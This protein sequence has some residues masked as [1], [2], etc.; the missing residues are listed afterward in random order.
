MV[1]ISKM[2]PHCESCRHWRAPEPRTEASD[3]PIVGECRRN[4]P[5]A[6]VM[7]WTFGTN[8]DD[9]ECA[10]AA[11][12]DWRAWPITQH[13]DWC[14]EWAKA[15]PPIA[16]VSRRMVGGWAGPGGEEDSNG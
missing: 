3:E 9:Q 4:P 6:L 7:A 2:R 12:V 16:E 14:G 13:A 8:H 15:D 10:D 5:V 1:A 11:S